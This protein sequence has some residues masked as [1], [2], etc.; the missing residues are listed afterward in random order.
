MRVKITFV[1]DQKF[2]NSIPLH[3][4]KLVFQ[5]LKNH[6]EKQGGFEG[7]INFSSLKGTAKIQNGFMRF[8]STKVTLVI[9]A[10]S[11]SIVDKVTDCIMSEPFIEV[12]EMHLIPKTMEHI[13]DPEFDT[14]MKYLCI[15]PLILCNPDLDQTECTDVIDPTSKQ[16]SDVLY[17]RVLNNME[18]AG[19]TDDELDQFAEFE[20]QPDPQYVEKI[21]EQGKKFARHYK[22]YEGQTLTGYLL[23]LTLHAHPKVHKF[24]WERGMGAYTDEGYG[25]VDVVRK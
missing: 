9:S 1:R 23:P 18:E 15:S 11:D 2:T 5:S 10:N 21:M 14:R 3:H 25:M 4:Q 8:L 17:D 7:T 20:A 24:I 6:C 19:Y 22:N 16:F 12:G 13:P